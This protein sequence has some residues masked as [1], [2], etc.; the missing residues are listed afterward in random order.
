MLRPRSETTGRI[1]PVAPASQTIRVLVLDQDQAAV[2][3]TP[4][5]EQAGVPAAVRSVASESEFT[6]AMSEFLP[7][8]VIA[9][10]SGEEFDAHAAAR[11]VHD[12]RPGTPLIMLV[13]RVDEASAVRALRRGIEDIVT[14]ERIER[15]PEAVGAALAVRRKLQLL[16]PRQLAVLQ[17]VAQGHTTR[18]I[19]R[20]MKI[21]IK[22]VETHRSALMKRLDMH[23]VATLV[24]YAVRVGLV[25]SDS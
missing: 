25:P 23:E 11:A 12:T 10:H 20:R 19:A 9:N 1:Q 6:R 4:V 3:L 15:L 5:L 18:E 14:F 16:S 17:S 22:T 13:D 8:V 24:R 2:R 21:S 7:D